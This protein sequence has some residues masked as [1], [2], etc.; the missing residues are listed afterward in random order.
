MTLSHEGDDLLARFS[1]LSFEALTSFFVLTAKASREGEERE[2]Q[3]VINAELVGAPE[4]RRQR[5]LASLLKNREELLRFLLMLLSGMG[6]SGQLDEA[7]LG[8]GK[9]A[10]AW[11][12]SSALFE[13]MVRALARD[14]SKIDEIDSIMQEL[15]KTQ[16]GRSI[17][18]EGWQDVWEP[19]RAARE[20]LRV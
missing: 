5:I 3:F 16:D 14:P 13:P 10:W 15:A 1:A 9:W 8:G 2:V 6:E 20:E 19:I 18:P 4:D 11:S 17:L 7:A 12:E